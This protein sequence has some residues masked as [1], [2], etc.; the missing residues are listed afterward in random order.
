MIPI[1]GD[2][3]V[4]GLG[5]PLIL[6]AGLAMAVVLVGLVGW[7]MM[8]ATISAEG[9]DSFDA[10]SRSYSY[11][12]Q[13]PWH[14]AW[15]SVVALAYGAV[16]VFFVGFMGSLVVY[17]GKWG[18]TQTPF[19]QRAD[20]DPS[21]LFVYAP[22]SFGWRTLL[23]EG[24]TVDGDPIVKGGEIDQK[25]L[26]KYMDT[27]HWYNYAGAVFVTAWLYLFFLLILGF[28]YS[29][30]WSASTIIYLL[31]RRRVDDTDLDEVYLEE[32]EPEES[33]STSTAAPGPKAPEPAPG[34]GTLQMVE[35][36]AIRTPPPASSPPPTEPPAETAVK[37][38]P[39]PT[40][41]TDG[42]PPPTGE[43]AGS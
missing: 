2:I 14:Y 32:D 17:L 5:W 8:Y 24:T 43:G 13:S 3:L 21:F 42:N 34:G 25:A 1:L 28:G 40:G 4:A 9:S 18:V 20:R 6:L 30:F 23:L 16:V 31:M 37:E 26:N 29:Y 22:T 36:P 7:P 39:A 19:I 10:I 38:V 27:F 35:A 41:G 12:Y 15:Y 33:Y 11:V